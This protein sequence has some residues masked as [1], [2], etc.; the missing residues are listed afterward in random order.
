M[1][2]EEREREGKRRKRKEVE[3]RRERGRKRENLTHLGH[4]AGL[5]GTPSL[6]AESQVPRRSLGWGPGLRIDRWRMGFGVT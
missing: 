3:R 4:E 1:A 6:C 2:E 5:S